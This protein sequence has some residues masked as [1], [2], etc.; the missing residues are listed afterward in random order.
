LIEGALGDP[1]PAVQLAAIA[2]LGRSGRDE[3]VLMVVSMTGMPRPLQIRLRALEALAE[4]GGEVAGA[5]E[6]RIQNSE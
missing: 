3:H 6:F 5:N 2:A 1:E 4:A